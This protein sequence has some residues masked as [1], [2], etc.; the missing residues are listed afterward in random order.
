[1]SSTDTY[2]LMC[3]CFGDD[4]PEPQ[5]ELQFHPTRNWRFDIAYPGR[6][7]VEIDGGQWVANG[8]RHNRDSDREKL[9]EAAVLGWRVLRFSTQQL[10]ADPEQCIE[11]VRRALQQ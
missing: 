11:T 10:D 1:M 3:R 9:N 8:G 6:V 5:I 7:A 4:L 2:L